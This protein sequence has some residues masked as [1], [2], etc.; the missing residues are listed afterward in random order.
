MIWMRKARTDL[1]GGADQLE[2]VIDDLGDK[3]AHIGYLSLS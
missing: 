1:R 2:T 3:L